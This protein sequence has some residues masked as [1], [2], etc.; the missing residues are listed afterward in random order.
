MRH[1]VIAKPRRLLRIWTYIRDGLPSPGRYKRYVVAMAPALIAVWTA[2]GAYLVLAPRSYT[3]HFTLILPGSGAGST[4]NVES[5]GQ[6]QSSAASAFSS[7]TLSPTENYKRLLMADITLRQ[8]AR[9]LKENEDAFPGPKVELTDQTNLIQIDIAGASPQQAQRRATALRQ[10]FLTQL[11]RL[12]ADEA[13]KREQ[14]D[15]RHLQ[16]LEAKVRETERALLAFQAQHG[17]VSVE[18]FNN[19]I[20]AIDSLRD[21]EREV[22]TTLRQQSAESS[23]FSSAL[24]A[25]TALG[26]NTLR[27]RSDPMFQRLVERYAALDADAEQKSAT[28]GEGHG[29]LA[30]VQAE[31]DTLRTALARRG[32]ELTGLGDEQLLRMVDLSVSDGRSS[33]IEGMIAADIRR[34]GTSAALRE[35][36]GD[37]AQ[38][39]GRAG[40]L[41]TQAAELADLT[42][43]HRIAEAVFSS[44]LA[45]VD[46]N[47]QDPFA[48]Y[49]LVQTLEE[50][51]LPR[52]PSSPSTVI[53]IAGATAA[54]I[55]IIMGFLLT[56]LRQPLIR[57]FFPNA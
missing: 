42:R 13:A 49:P 2:T 35:I 23:R 39:Q 17:M 51:S 28:L 6:A 8:S 19:R 25:G 57:K 7:T 16:E 1:E 11:D 9:I 43:D 48:S 40:L 21:R 14:A 29:D 55:L 22:R 18:Q 38:Q 30:Q 4:L 20:S 45:R 37:L 3:S 44:A 26:N 5:I 46:T 27:L 53:A 54:T 36:R 15:T 10:A 52:G 56:W 33:L 50:P 24:N 47:K 31:R 34:A 32:R 12:R 41:V